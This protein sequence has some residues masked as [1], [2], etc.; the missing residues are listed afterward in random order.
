[1][2]DTKKAHTRLFAS[3][4]ILLTVWIVSNY[5]T[6]HHIVNLDVTNFANKLAFVSGFGVLLSAILFTYNFPIKKKVSNLEAVAVTFV[7]AIVII[8]S[9]TESVTGVVTLDE[10]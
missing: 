6:N 5:V 9:M 8:L 1:M 3:V 10:Q 4:S 2:R 7:S